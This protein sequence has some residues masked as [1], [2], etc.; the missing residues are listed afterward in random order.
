M[1]QTLD[2]WDQQLMLLLNH[3]GGLW[4]DAF[5]YAYS[6]K[7]TWIPA[8]ISIIV[9]FVI[10]CRTSSLPSRQKWGHFAILIAITV[11]VV[12]IADQI[13]SGLIKHLVERP[14]PSHQPNIEHLLH[15][16]NDYHGGRYGF[17]SSHAANSVGIAI[18]I[19]LLCRN[20]LL[21]WSLALWAIAN[22]W[23]RI[24][25]GV[26]YVGDLLGGSL[27][28]LFAGYICWRIYCAILQKYFQTTPY[29]IQSGESFLSMQ[30]PLCILITLWMTI[31]ILAIYSAF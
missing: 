13:S 22:C 15:Y 9:M 20:R 31:L 12:A 27:V 30:K 7:F 4:A 19:G 3:N 2:L 11:L 17:V 26:H 29:Q 23:S 14:R 1:I 6:Y 18:W 5:W 21:S 16:V 28:G 8:A 25:L 24:Y 10:Q